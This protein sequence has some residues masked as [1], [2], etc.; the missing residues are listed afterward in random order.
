MPTW[1]HRTA[2]VPILRE[3]TNIEATYE[4]GRER[5]GAARGV[6]QA[7]GGVKRWSRLGGKTPRSLGSVEPLP[8][9]AYEDGRDE[10]QTDHE[11]S[12]AKRVEHV[13]P[14]VPVVSNFELLKAT[15]GG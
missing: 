1:A 14:V 4:Y 5:S 3:A 6:R 7:Y 12:H 8:R 13:L 2:L 11:C 10:E 15:F 9:K